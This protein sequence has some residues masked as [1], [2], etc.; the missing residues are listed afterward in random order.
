MLFSAPNH[1]GRHESYD[2]QYNLFSGKLTSL[3]SLSI[4]QFGLYMALKNNHASSYLC[5]MLC[6]FS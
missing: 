4:K 2:K 1:Y 6:F 5:P 3:I